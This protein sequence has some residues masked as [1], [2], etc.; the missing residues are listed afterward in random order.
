MILKSSEELAPVVNNVL[1]ELGELFAR[2][3]PDITMH[4][5]GSTAIPGALTKGDIDVLLRVENSEFQ[6]TVEILKKHFTIRQAE[7]WTATFASFGTDTDYALPLGIQVVIKDSDADF[8]LFI[9][10]F[11]V[12]NPDRLTEYNEL[13]LGNADKGSKAYWSAKNKLLSN[14]IAPQKKAN[15]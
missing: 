14:I 5:I 1:R 6:F 8:F 2:I 12:S 3:L 15:P 4:H 13:K 7:N 11:F 10:N 9:H